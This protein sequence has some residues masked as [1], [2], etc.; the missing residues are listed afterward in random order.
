MK[1]HYFL[2]LILLGTSLVIS[3]YVGNE[4]NNNNS[5]EQLKNLNEIQINIPEWQIDDNA[6]IN[7][8]SEG[9]QN[10]LNYSIETKPY[11]FV[12]ETFNFSIYSDSAYI[13][14]ILV[15]NSNYLFQ[16]ISNNFTLDLRPGVYLMEVVFTEKNHTNYTSFEVLPGEMEIYPK[17]VFVNE[18]ITL[19]V[20]DYIGKSFEI[21]IIP[22]DMTFNIINTNESF[23][24]NLSFDNEGNYTIFVNENV[25]SIEVLNKEVLSLKLDKNIA[26]VNQSINFQI[27]GTPNTFF[28]LSI[29]ARDVV[30]IQIKGFTNDQGFYNSSFL[31]EYP[32]NYTAIFEYGKN[33]HYEDIVVMKEFKA[34]SIDNVKNIYGRNV[35]FYVSGPPS[36]DFYLYFSSE[37]YTK[38]YYL[39]TN[40]F[41]MHSFEDEFDI[42]I[43]NLTLTYDGFS[44]SKMFSVFD[45]EKNIIGVLGDDTVLELTEDV[46]SDDI[47][48]N[49][50]GNNVTLNCNG[51]KIKARNFGIL[52]QD[53]S[54]VNIQD[55]VIADSDIGIMI[56]NSQDVSIYK[57]STLNNSNGVIAMHT[58]NISLFDSDLTENEYYGLLL[59]A[60]SNPIVER[61]SVKTNTNLDIL[62]KLKN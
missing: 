60:V 6:S 20:R 25:F 40:S 31:V 1:R 36:T 27:N 12:N 53:S 8:I 54:S 2:L 49:I 34:F 35:F 4:I 62:S 9:L 47:G 59:F 51:F 37:N 19:H 22:S 3:Q 43:Y 18:N 50:Q 61:T 46:V 42:G 41:G 16:N 24:F 23:D 52:I 38:V 45:K 48:I 7:V 5:E 13:V 26:F 55:C 44:V 39:R 10:V 17:K 15:N 56:K 21:R 33:I 28:N 29:A 58:K 32:G 14:N 57:I 30:F 11:Y